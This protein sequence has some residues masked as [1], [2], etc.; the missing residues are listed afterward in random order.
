MS[1]IHFSKHI[2]S[3]GVTISFRI[4]GWSHFPGVYDYWFCVFSSPVVLDFEK[5]PTSI[6]FYSKLHPGLKTTHSCKVSLFPCLSSTLKSV[7]FR[8]DTYIINRNI[9]VLKHFPLS[10]RTDV[11][12][13]YLRNL[14]IY[15]HKFEVYIE[16]LL[17]SLKNSSPYS[18]EHTT[19]PL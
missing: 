17:G 7:H 12:N 8:Q 5:W 18:P 13:K 2:P 6:P 14:T 19:K 16:N 9:L 3:Q 11:D 15:P 4:L 1:P 10:F